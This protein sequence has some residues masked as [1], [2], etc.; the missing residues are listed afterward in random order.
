MTN[1]SRT[2]KNCRMNV[3]V[4][5]LPPPE[6]QSSDLH[7]LSDDV[8]VLDHCRH[9]G[10]RESSASVEWFVWLSVAPGRQVPSRSLG[11]RR[12]K[13]QIAN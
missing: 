6:S 5:L 13:S 4:K 8:C 2:V 3:G 10:T 7:D 12:W 11:A 9:V 1:D